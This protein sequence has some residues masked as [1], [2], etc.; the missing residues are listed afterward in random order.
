LDSRQLKYFREIVDNGSM[1]GAARNLGI[2]QPSLS[3]LVRNLEETLGVELL[4][5]TAR[6]IV[7]TQ[8][9]ERLYN[10]A[11]QIENYI[12]AAREDVVNIGSQPSGRVLFGMPPTISMALSIPM[13]ETIRI[14]MPK[15][16]FAAIEAMTGHLREWIIKG[17][18]DLALLYDNTNIG[19]CSNSLLLTEDLWFYS[20]AEDWPFSTPPLEPVDL[21]AVLATEL[22]LPSERHGLRTFIERIALAHQLEPKVSIEMD[23]LTQIKALVARGSGYTILSPASMHDLVSDGTLVGSPIINPHLRRNVFLVRSSNAGVTLACR[24]T[25]ETCREVVANLVTRGIWQA[26]LP[27]TV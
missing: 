18:L 25:E 11:R 23:S 3:Q 22:V 4:I 14:E 13:A 24:R 27:D 26:E 8:A 9:G 2:A 16:K 10:H 15:V 6:G 1:S 12:N 20:A 17:E 7:P 21:K 5:R 19:D